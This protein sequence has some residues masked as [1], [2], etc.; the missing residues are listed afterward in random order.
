[1]GQQGI[2]EGREKGG[3]EA[4]DR[5]PHRVWD[6]VGARG[7]CVRGFGEG[8]GYL[9]GGEGGIVLIVREAQEGGRWG[10]GRKKVV[11]KRFR[12]LGRVGGPWQVREPLW[13]ATKWEPLGRPEGA[14]SGRGQEA[15]PVSLLGRGD[16]LKICSPR[17]LHI[18]PVEGGRVEAGYPCKLVIFPS[19]RRQARGLPWFR[20]GARV[21]ARGMGGHEGG[22]VGRG[23]VEPPT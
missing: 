21:F 12:H 8:P 18:A 11:N 16:G 3:L 4:V 7:G 14:W 5:L 22:K 19:Q 1:M 9:F 10:F 17:A 2:Q 15:R 23:D 20:A 6:V 13:W